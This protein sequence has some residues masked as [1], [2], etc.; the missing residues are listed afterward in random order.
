[1]WRCLTTTARR[2]VSSSC[3]SSSF[4]DCRFRI[5][6]SAASSSSSAW[7]MGFHVVAL[8]DTGRGLRACGQ[9]AWAATGRQQAMTVQVRERH[10]T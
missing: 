5:S 8:A 9:R 3:A 1:M 2:L 4:R 6:V 7:V 10:V